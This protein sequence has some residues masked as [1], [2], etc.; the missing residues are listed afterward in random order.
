MRAGSRKSRKE[1]VNLA[2][3]LRNAK[4]GGTAAGARR[5]RLPQPP[6]GP[7]PRG[8]RSPPA[9]ES[10][11]G[12]GRGPTGREEPPLGETREEEEEAEVLPPPEAEPD[13]SFA[14]GDMEA[15][16]LQDLPTA[17]IACNLDPR[18]FQDGQCRVRAAR[19]AVLGRLPLPARAAARLGPSRPAPAP[20]SVRRG[21]RLGLCGRGRAGQ[22]WS[23]GGGG[24]GG[25]RASSLHWPRHGE[26]VVSRGLG[27]HRAF[28]PGREGCEQNDEPL[29]RSRVAAAVR[30]MV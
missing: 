18:V 17:T 4:V 7:A 22:R 28:L 19:R 14:G 6:P 1:T 8:L 21:R 3:G 30:E 16:V 24:V 5:S 23:R 25:G 29:L 9:M 26:R 20:P 15:V 27:G 10:G 11:S 13:W 12:G 2:Q